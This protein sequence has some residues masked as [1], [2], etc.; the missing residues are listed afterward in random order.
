MKNKKWFKQLILSHLAILCCFGAAI[1]CITFFVTYSYLVQDIQESNSAYANQVAD[2]ITAS[3]K[4]MERTLAGQMVKNEAINAFFDSGGAETK[5]INYKASSEMSKIRSNPLIQSVY[6]Y[7]S[8]DQTVL[9]GGYITGLSG[10]SDKRFVQSLQN[11]PV[12]DKWSSLR[13]YTEFPL[14]DPPERIVS[15]VKKIGNEGL[16]VLN[17]KADP[18]LA[19]AGKLKS[20]PRSFMNIADDQGQAIYS[21]GPAE[22]STRLLAHLDSNY[23]GWQFTSGT[24]TGNLFGQAALLSLIPLSIIVLALAAIVAVILYV[25]RRSYR[26]IENMVQRVS[27]YKGELKTA[28]SDEFSIIEQAFD[29]MLIRMDQID[30]QQAE[31][32]RYKRRQFFSELQDCENVVPAEEWQAYAALLGIPEQGWLAIA[33][34][35]IDKYVPLL[36]QN[37]QNMLDS[38]HKLS[39]L[40]ETWPEAETAAIYQDWLS[41]DRLALLMLIRPGQ[42]ADPAGAAAAALDKLRSRAEQELAFTVTI[43][44]G[45]TIQELPELKNS[46]AEALA[47]LQYKMT[48]GN[49]RVL[50]HQEIRERENAVSPLYFKWIEDLVHHFRILQVEWKNDFARIFDYLEE[51]LLKNE[52]IQLLLNY[53]THRFARE[54]EEISPDINEYWHTATYPRMSEAL[55]EMEATTK[56]RELYREL[57]DNL[58][59]K[60]NDILESGSTDHLIYV[61]K[62]YI[63]DNFADPDLSL[64]SISDRFGINGKYASQL[65]KEE[66]EVKFVDFLINLRLEAAQKLLRETHESVSEISRRVGYEHAISFG[67][68]FK[69]TVGMAPGDYRKLMQTAE[70]RASST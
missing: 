67:R 29:D 4:N 41:A 9:T 26:P 39:E 51:H 56:I 27:S 24:A 43:G 15:I 5:L 14:I 63:E 10:F 47:A 23:I 32:L 64:K 53:L 40:A 11:G 61:V 35:E 33:I 3:L 60:Y 22:K 37:R 18:L 17:V 68:I 48:A 70:G 16:I 28:N 54:M 1:I 45:S 66:F 2:N 13:Y 12:G 36:R 52:E 62:K 7:R 49:N 57:L 44:A 59:E 58:Y 34:L 38:K 25:M 46:F 30:Q 21:T 69:K 42:K 65:F 6:F 55:K 31:N 50:I 8:K 20:N 19:T